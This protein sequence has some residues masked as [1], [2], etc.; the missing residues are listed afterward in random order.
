VKSRRQGTGLWIIQGPTTN[1]DET[2]PITVV[3]KT[4]K[5]I[6]ALYAYL[7]HTLPQFG[8]VVHFSVDGS[9]FLSIMRKY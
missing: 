8:D 6:N 7:K 3:F 9:P 1:R 2:N 4:A 5:H